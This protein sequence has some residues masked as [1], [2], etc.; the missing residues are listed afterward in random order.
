MICIGNLSLEIGHF[1][2]RQWQMKICNDPFN[3]F[4]SVPSVSP[5]LKESAQQLKRFVE[6]T[7]DAF[8]IG[9]LAHFF[10]RE[11]G[12][13]VRFVAHADILIGMGDE[14]EANVVV[15]VGVVDDVALGV[16]MLRDY[17]NVDVQR[18]QRAVDPHEVE[19]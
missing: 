14:Q 6:H 3:W 17:V 13:I 5:W 9:A 15:L 4:F 1:R 18:Q 2:Y 12:D 19:R 8:F 16:T 10:R 7:Q 11:P